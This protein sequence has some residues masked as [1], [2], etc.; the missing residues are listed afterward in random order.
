MGMTA[1]THPLKEKELE[2]ER[3]SK[4]ERK[5][6]E[7]GKETKK[8]KIKNILHVSKWQESIWVISIAERIRI[9]YPETHK[10]YS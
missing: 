5:K 4:G 7:R 10:H 1:Y 2:E 8:R 6:G 3:K 9:T